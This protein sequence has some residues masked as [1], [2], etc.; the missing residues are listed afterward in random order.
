MYCSLFLFQTQNADKLPGFELLYTAVYGGI[1]IVGGSKMGRKFLMESGSHIPYSFVG[2]VG[3]KSGTHS[4]MFVFYA[5]VLM[6]S[7]LYTTKCG[8]KAGCLEER[9]PG[10]I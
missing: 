6:H 7:P 10:I 3:A 9:S 5:Y 4:Y 8:Q 2:Y 1:H